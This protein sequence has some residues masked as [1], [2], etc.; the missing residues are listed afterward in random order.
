MV[1]NIKYFSRAWLTVGLLAIVACLNYADRLMLTTMRSSIKESIEMTDAQFGLLTAVFLWVYALLSPFAGFLA[2]RFG[3]SRV[4]I[5]GLIVWSLITWMTAHATTLNHLLITRALMGISEACYI[6]AAL[7]L[8]ADYHRGPTRSLA[9][10]VH[11]LGISLGTSMG[12]LGGYIAE[13][14]HWTVTFSLFGGVGVAYA[15]VLVFLLRDVS[16]TP[17]ETGFQE[18][19]P[20]RLNKAFKSLFSYGSFY[21]AIAYWGLLGVAGW[22]I[23]GW[24]PTFLGE[25]FNLSQG[26]A[27]VSATG[28]LQPAA[29]I[30]LILGGALA[31]R[32]ARYHERGRIYLV[33]LALLIAV[34]S[35]LLG[36]HTQ[37]YVVAMIGFMMY[38]AASGATD[39]NMMPILCLV[40]DRR[41]RATGFGVL[42]FLACAI[43]GVTIYAGGILRDAKVDMAYIFEAAAAAMLICVLL[44]LA[45]RPLPVSSKLIGKDNIIPMS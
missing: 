21:L 7:A 13:K 25:R 8:I 27:G 31:D 29:W 19:N 37:S 24:L 17:S 36:S 33:V 26:L 9:M 4:I 45:I 40:T 30:G 28:Y 43:G 1:G 10:G 41:Y 32:W 18:E 34:P 16:A 42:N 44:L 38:Q 3:R 35:L 2:D 22:L 15:L 23:S 12:G 39:S 5:T 20:V 14:H 11:M 6:P